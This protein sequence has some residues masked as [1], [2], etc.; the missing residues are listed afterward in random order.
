MEDKAKTE[1]Y[2]NAG[3]LWGPGAEL[4]SQ[5]S[6]IGEPQDSG[7]EPSATQYEAFPIFSQAVQEGGGPGAA[8][9]KLNTKTGNEER[10]FQAEGR[11][12]SEDMEGRRCP[13]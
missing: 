9:G 5:R 10:I 1:S 2:G 13:G 12:R 8:P 6:D 3:Q 7:P 4:G 11:G